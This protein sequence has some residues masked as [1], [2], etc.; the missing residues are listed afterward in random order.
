M[1]L[2]Q[3]VAF[4]EQRNQTLEQRNQTLE[5][6][7]LTMERELLSLK[8]RLSNVSEVAIEHQRDLWLLRLENKRMKVFLDSSNERARLLN[9]KFDDLMGVCAVCMERSVDTQRYLCGTPE[10]ERRCVNQ[11]CGQCLC[12]RLHTCTPGK[13]CIICRDAEINCPETETQPH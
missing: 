4:A 6:Q 7:S 1:T 2:Q 10:S 12:K 3:C 5:L 13:S 11:M 8:R 9:K